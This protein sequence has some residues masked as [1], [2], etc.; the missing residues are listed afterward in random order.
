MNT[1]VLSSGIRYS[2]LPESYIRPE[3]ERP[4][5]SEVSECENVPVIDLGS[6]NRIQVVQ[7]IGDACKCYGF[8]QVINHGVPLGIAKEMGEVAYEFFK[9]PVE[10]KMKLYSDDPSR[11]MRLSTSFNMNKETVHNW[12]DYLRLHCYPLD[13]YVPEWPSNP[14]TFKEI[15]TKY[16]KEVRE[17][18]FR[19]QEHI[20][21]SLGL[22]KDYMKN[23]L[24]EQGQ[25]MAVNYYPACPEPELTYGLPGHTDPNALTILLQ[26]QNVAGLQ[27]LKDGKWLAVNPYPDAFVI[28]IG[29]QFQALSNG[30]YKSVWHRAV[31][32]VDKPRLSVASFLCPYDEALISPAKPLTE[33]GTGAIYRGYTYAE[34]YKKFWSRDL[35]DKEHCLELFKNN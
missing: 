19:I 5:L 2:T 9:L 15:V 14:H 7:Q 21:E 23:V 10:E 1:K 20:S 27:V 30:I 29:D 33:N 32:N 35:V 12:R 6:H 22:E 18:G 28:N 17:L 16:C 34:Y 25:H 13:K 4:R 8:F 3:S 11:T 31:V 26:D 24:G